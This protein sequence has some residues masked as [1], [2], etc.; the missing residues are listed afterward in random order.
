[1]SRQLI[2]FEVKKFIR[3][4]WQ[5]KP[6][7][8]RQAFPHF[9]SPVTPE[10]LAGLA[11]E[12][13]V[14]SR[15][16]IEKDADTPWQ[17]RYGP[18]DEKTFQTLPESH[19]TLLVS[20]CEKW[21]PE[22]ADLLELFRFIPG[23]RIDDLMVSYAPVGGS[24]GPHFDEYDVFLLQAYG[25]RKW[26]YTDK[27]VENPALIPDLDLAI[28]SEFSFDREA[29]LGPG[30]LLYLPPG[31]AHQGVATE[32]CMTISIGFRAPAANEILDAFLLEMDNRN[33]GATRYVDP[34]LESDRHF[35][36]ISE[37]EIGRFKSLVYSLLEQPDD[38]W[39]DTA[40]KLLSDSVILGPEGKERPV[41]YEQ[42]IKNRWVINP[43]SKML[44]HRGDT[45][46]MFYCNGRAFE[47]PNTDEVIDAVQNLCENR[48]LTPQLIEA[49]RGN[50]P[51]TTL[52]GE[53]VAISAVI[54]A[55]D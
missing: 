14:H 54:P 31:I 2:N 21:V 7:L 4:Y 25:Q 12:K 51:L 37:M 33:L 13:E 3:Q 16:V 45:V 52:V 18:F 32:P 24:V 28:L 10:E 30:D 46:L 39:R 48:L 35:A 41:G 44:Y 19:Y 23:W 42:I 53:L 1:M 11:C 26:Q 27:R 20:E 55:D 15:L 43:D 5:K 50:E 34:D 36:E 49:C 8:I 6:F 22:L 38:L 9:E 40:G 47:L 29:T 17:V